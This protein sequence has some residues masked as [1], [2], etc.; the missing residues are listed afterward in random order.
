M[1]DYGGV[2]FRI[3]LTQR[4]KIIKRRGSGLR[5][6]EFFYGKKIAFGEDY[7]RFSV[8]MSLRAVTIR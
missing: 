5:K 2:T 1:K 7:L 6:L 8:V 3:S 4:V